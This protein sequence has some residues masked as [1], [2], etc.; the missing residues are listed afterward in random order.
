MSKPKS[1]WRQFYG[2]FLIG[3]IC[4]VVFTMVYAF[5]YN[6]PL[7]LILFYAFLIAGMVASLIHDYKF[8]KELCRSKRWEE[9]G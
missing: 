6:A 2:W 1:Y 4:V 5:T 8:W 7:V 9:E 3:A